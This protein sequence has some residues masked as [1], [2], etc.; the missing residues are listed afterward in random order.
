MSM[1]WLIYPGHFFSF[2]FIFLLSSDFPP[3]LHSPSPHLFTPLPHF[4]YNILSYFI[5]FFTEFSC[6]PCWLQYLFETKIR[7]CFSVIYVHEHVNFHLFQKR[8]FDPL[9]LELRP[10]WDS[11]ETELFQVL[12]TAEPSFQSTAL[13]CVWTCTHGLLKDPGC[14]TNAD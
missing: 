4:F 3:H 10:A 6:S 9:D 7:I 11:L 13:S 14:N 8:M 5:F 1:I 12:L 2:S